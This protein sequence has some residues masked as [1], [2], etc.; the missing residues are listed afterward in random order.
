MQP[1]VGR[2][3]YGLLYGHNGSIA[4][5]RKKQVRR[6][7]SVRGEEDEP[8][9]EDLFVFVFVWFVVNMSKAG[10]GIAV[11]RPPH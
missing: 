11:I 9:T 2:Y 8:R 10:D 5:K 7:E 1:P 6:G 4:W 3:D